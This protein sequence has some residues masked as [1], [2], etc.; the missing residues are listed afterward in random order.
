MALRLLVLLLQGVPEGH[1]RQYSGARHRCCGDLFLPQVSFVVLEDAYVI[2]TKPGK[3]R[4]ILLPTVLVTLPLPPAVAPLFPEGA[5]DFFRWFAFWSFALLLTVPWLLSIHQLLIHSLS[6]GV[7]AKQILSDSAAPKIAVVIPCYKEIPEI[8]MRTI[9]SV[10]DS[11]YSASCLHVFLSFDEDT[12]DERYLG[13]LE[14]LGV[15]LV[16]HH[17]FPVSIDAI[18]KGNRITVSRF[19]HGGKRN[20]QKHTFKLMERIYD[21]YAEQNDDVFILFVD[22]DCMLDKACIRSLMYDMELK[23]SSRHSMIAMT[24]VVTPT[25]AK[26][27]LITLLQDIEYCRGQLIERAS[28]SACGAVTCLPGALTVIRFST[29]R[30]VAGSYFADRPD[31]CQDLFDYAKCHLGERTSHILRLASG[32]PYLS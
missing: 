1:E 23:P 3:S 26:N 27:S 24:G 10:V 4:G 11:D 19:P 15:L 32:L 12:E 8:L 16:R 2:P 22:S 7:R 5:V 25:T 20:C 17:G 6:C 31:A 13:T 29:F 14:R 21:K 18:Y 9:N 30:A 28:E